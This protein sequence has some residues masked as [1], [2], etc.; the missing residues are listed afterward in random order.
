MKKIMTF[1]ICLF[2]LAVATQAQTIGP[3]LNQASRNL[4]TAV[5]RALQKQAK[6]LSEKIARALLVDVG[7]TYHSYVYNKLGQ[8][9]GRQEKGIAC[10]GMFVNA[11]GYI[12]V[13]NECIKTLQS[14]M[15]KDAAQ[16][17]LEV[18]K[19]SLRFHAI[20]Y[21]S[22]DNVNE[23]PF[24]LYSFV[25]QKDEITLKNF[26]QENGYYGISIKD[27]PMDSIFMH[28]MRDQGIGT[29][30]IV[31]EL[32]RYLKELFNRVGSRQL[33]VETLRY[34]LYKHHNT[35]VTSQFLSDDI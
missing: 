26:K 12:A 18:I 25:G 16:D 10:Q 8:Q 5:E 2:V 1:V 4:N 7:F 21:G 14:T 28:Q 30:D 17:D 11:A 3:R 32:L 33:T 9:I 19:D 34:Q 35:K 22:P 24:L 27:I 29:Q 6:P 15:A 20:K 13:P 23:K 31:Q